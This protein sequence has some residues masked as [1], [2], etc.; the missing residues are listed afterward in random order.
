MTIDVTIVC[1]TYNRPHDIK[2][3]LTALK[4]NLFYSQGKLHYLIADDCSPNDYGY[5]MADWCHHHISP[6]TSLSRMRVNS[7]WGANANQ[8]IANVQTPLYILI[9]DDY[10][11]SRPMNLDP[12]ARILMQEESLG[13]VR[14]DGILGHRVIAQMAEFSLEGHQDGKGMGGKYNYWKLSYESPEL[15]LYSNR[16]HLT[17]KARWHGYYGDYEQ[18]LK[19]GETEANMAWRYKDRMDEE[20]APQI[21]VPCSLTVGHFDHIGVSYQGTEHD[22]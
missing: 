7:G 15:W 20:G 13:I 9:E 19:L 4:D 2:Q 22:K 8:A 16:P 12:H 10:V 18:G 17:H 11:L 3:T 14:L 6:H 5:H 21:I 1:I